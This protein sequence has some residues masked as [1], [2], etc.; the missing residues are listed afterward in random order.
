[1]CGNDGA[2]TRDHVFP[3]ALFPRGTLP[4]HPPPPIV[5]ACD[6]CQQR[7]QPDEEYFRT[8]VA[9]GA[10]ADSVARDLWEGQIARSFDN[11]PG[12]RQLFASAIRTMEWI[13]PG[14]AF[15]GEVT[16][17]E[18]DRERIGN[19]LMKI[20]RGL[21][22]LDS[23]RTVMP[24]DVHFNY[25]QVSPMTPPF[26]EEVMDVIHGMPLRTVGDVVR[27]KFELSP[28]EPRIIVS[29]FAFYSRSMF[30]VWT[31]PAGVELPPP[32]NAV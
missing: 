30:V 24:F 15:I 11:S 6:G 4:A 12:L 26:P 5:P 29:W 27:Y 21:Y 7:L 3:R 17:V 2:R 13:S 31:R 16:G 20:V 14:G 18:G 22:Y 25:A 28:D 19:V 1:M 23:G 32:P 9:S 10:Y 8:L